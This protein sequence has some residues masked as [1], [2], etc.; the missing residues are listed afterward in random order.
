[1]DINQFVCEF[2]A[3]FDDTDASEFYAGL[4]FKQLEEW[5]SL[6]GLGIIAMCKKKYGVKITGAEI[7]E[8]NT[9]Q[10]IYEIVSDRLK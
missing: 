8:A 6:S 4:Q 5:S 9:I 3:C 10:D 7:R 2:A 1:M